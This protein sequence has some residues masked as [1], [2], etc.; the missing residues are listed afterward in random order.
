MGL[1][2][3]FIVYRGRPW[4]NTYIK[5]LNYYCH[6]TTLSLTLHMRKIIKLMSLQRN[7]FKYI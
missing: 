3:N 2:Y 6:V 7:D 4:G 1:K 5:I